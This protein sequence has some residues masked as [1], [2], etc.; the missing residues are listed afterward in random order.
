MTTLQ[1]AAL[2]TG[3]RLEH[4]LD[5]FTRTHKVVMADRGRFLGTRTDQPLLTQLRQA[6]TTASTYNPDP[7]EGGALAK[8]ERTTLNTTAVRLYATIETRVHDWAIRAGYRRPTGSW[9]LP[10]QILRSWWALAK[11]DVD[12]DGYATQLQAWKAEIGHLLDPPH[13]FDIDKPCPVCKAHILEVETEGMTKRVRA[14]SGVERDPD[15]HRVS[16]RACKTEW[17]GLDAAQELADEIAHADLLDRIAQRWQDTL[18]AWDG[19]TA[20]ELA[21]QQVTA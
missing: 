15:I 6:K 21:K 13:R 10:E 19:L 5:Q 18:A 4:L 8:H 7:G 2:D 20:I 17:D 16:C 11:H 9:P 12:P 14:L 1:R 3:H